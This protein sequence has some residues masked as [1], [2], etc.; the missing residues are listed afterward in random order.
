MGDPVKEKD[1]NEELHQAEEEVRKSSDEPQTV[2]EFVSRYRI[3]HPKA[4]L[5]SI[6]IKGLDREFVGKIGSFDEVMKFSKLFADNTSE[7]SE[8]A[9]SFIQKYVVFPN[10]THDELAHEML[11]GH[12]TN[13]LK[14]V[15]K[16]NGFEDE[17]EIK[18]L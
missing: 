9:I 13:L 17:A 4:V 8:T 3:K 11:P 14:G 10:L 15:Q 6:K 2:P 18:K 1:I 5:F 7:V 12:V 16:A